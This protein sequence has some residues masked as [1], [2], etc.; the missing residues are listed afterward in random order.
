MITTF[1]SFDV[2]SIS[3]VMGG[4][5][6]DVPSFIVNFRLP[7]GVLV[8]YAEIPEKFLPFLKACYDSSFDSAKLPSMDDMTPMERTAARFLV[9]DDDHKNGTLKIVPVVVKGPWIVKSVVRGKPAILG[10]SIPMSYFYSPRDGNK[11]EYLEVD[12]DIAASSAARSIL[13]VCTSYTKSLTIDLGFVIEGKTKD[14]LPEQMLTAARLHGIDPLNAPTLP[15][16]KNM[17]IDN[18]PSLDEEDLAQ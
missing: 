6:R 1:F 8:F 2:R 5:L 18:V 9:G 12:L 16:M 14:E 17:F 10:N 13:S 7:W 11:A 3:G 4:Q 15:P